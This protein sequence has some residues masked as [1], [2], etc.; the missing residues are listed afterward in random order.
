[1]KAISNV[2]YSMP[3]NLVVFLG[4]PI[5]YFLFVLAYDPFGM[6]DFLSLGKERFT[7]NIILTTLILSGVLVLS[8]ML[9]F[10]LRKNISLNWTLYIIWCVCE[11]VFAGMMFSILLGIGWKGTLPYLNVMPRCILYL[12]G[13]TVFPY[14]VIALGTQVYVLRRQEGRTVVDERTLVRFYDEQKRLKLILSSEA[15]LYVEAEENYVHIFHLDGGRVKDYT[16][17]SSMRALDET[18]TNKGLVRCHRSYFVNPVHVTLV[19]KDTGGYA[20]AALDCDGVK[21][22]PVSKKYYEALSALL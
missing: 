14:A 8:R 10:I 9:M 21:P 13:I 7:L 6:Q 17:R 11:V 22:V 3:V 5:F 15:I 12:A 18:L 16:L 19:R 2:H 1:M 20:L 4:I